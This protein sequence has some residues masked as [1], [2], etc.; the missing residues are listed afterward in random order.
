MTMKPETVEKAKSLLGLIYLIITVPLGIIILAD[1]IAYWNYPMEPPTAKFLLVVQETNGSAY[2]E[3]LVYIKI[4]ANPPLMLQVLHLNSSGMGLSYE[5]PLT[6]NFTFTVYGWPRV[7]R[8]YAT[9]SS[10]QVVAT[11]SK[12]FDLRIRRPYDELPFLAWLLLPRYNRMPDPVVIEITVEVPT[13]TIY[14]VGRGS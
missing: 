3:G 10:P 2:T 5:W 12:T 9:P 8:L 14:G 1:L 11:T 6:G 7:V 4:M 13:I